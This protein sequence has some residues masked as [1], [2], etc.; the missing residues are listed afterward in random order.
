VIVR[1]A[2]A[3]GVDHPNYIGGLVI[4]NN[5][6]TT[7]NHTYFNKSA[8]TAEALGTMGNANARFFHGPGINNWDM[9]LQKI[10]RI[11]ESMSAQFRAEFFSLMEHA[12]FNN[13][14]GNFTSSSF[15]RVTSAKAGRIGQMSLKFLW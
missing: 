12:L 1:L 8:F 9:G 6:R 7:P 14:N 10:T 3:G 11:R 15:G 2:G 4:N 13:P 5:V